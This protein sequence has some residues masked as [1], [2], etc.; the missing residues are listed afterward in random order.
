MLLTVV[1][2]LLWLVVTELV[3]GV[4][5][6]GVVMGILVSGTVVLSDGDDSELVGSGSNPS[7]GSGILDSQS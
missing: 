4:V 1:T 7:G 3:V 6:V 5:P 2:V